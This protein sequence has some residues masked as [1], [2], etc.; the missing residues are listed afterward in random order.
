[1]KKYI[2]I[3]ALIFIKGCSSSSEDPALTPIAKVL[4]VNNGDGD[5]VGV[6]GESS[7]GTKELFVLTSTDAND[8]TQNIIEKGEVG[9]IEITKCNVLWDL[10]YSVSISDDPLDNIIQTTGMQ[11][12]S[13]DTEYV[14]TC[15]TQTFDYFG[16]Q[17]TLTQCELS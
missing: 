11:M 10:S 8:A 6:M 13:C 15:K 17:I 7:L 12:Y 3:L 9:V 2:A 16:Q 5:I 4:F 14:F 1:M